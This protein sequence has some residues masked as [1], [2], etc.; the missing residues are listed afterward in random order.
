MA[1]D[2]ATKEPTQIRAGDTI[3]WEK[4][5]DDYPAGGS[6]WVLKYAFRGTAGVIDVTATA[7]GTD[8][9]VSIAPATSTAYASGHYDVLGFVEKGSDRY[10][11]FTGRIEVLADLEAEGSS[12]DGR[13]HTKKVLDKIEA[14]LESRATKEIL[15]SMIEGVQIKRIPHEELILMRSKYLQW[16]QQ[17]IAAEKIAAGMGTGRNILARFQ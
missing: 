6:E 9:L 1:A 3:K 17:E 11:I 4:S 2:I 12:Y 13:T 16:H 8:H 7:D 15:E 10:T 14:V 5:L